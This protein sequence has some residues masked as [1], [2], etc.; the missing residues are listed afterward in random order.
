MKKKVSSPEQQSDKTISYSLKGINIRKFTMIEPG[1]NITTGFD[2]Q[3]FYVTLTVDYKYEDGF[4]RIFFHIFNVYELNDEK[5][6][7]LEL[8]FTTD[9]HITDKINFIKFDNEKFNMSIDFLTNLTSIAYS[10]A[11]GIIFAKT[12]GSYLNQY[13]LPVIDPRI[14][15]QQKLALVQTDSTQKE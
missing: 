9:F 2:I 15:V 8:F 10:T 14:L 5:I 6:I 1:T 13:I 3:K 12:Q 11:R 4:F 7:L